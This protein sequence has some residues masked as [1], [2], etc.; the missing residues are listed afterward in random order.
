MRGGVITAAMNVNTWDV[1]DDL[2]VLI[3]RN[4]DGRQLANRQAALN[5]L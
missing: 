4:I 2:R 1:N 5:D 3:G